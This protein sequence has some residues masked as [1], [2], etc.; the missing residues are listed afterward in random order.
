MPLM[1]SW[2]ATIFTAM[3][4][5]QAPDG[6]DTLQLYAPV[7]V[8]PHGG[9]TS[10]R[11]SAA[12]ELVASAGKSLFGLDRLELGRFVESPDD[13]SQR[14]GTTNGCLYHVDHL[15]T[16]IGPL[17]PALGAG[18]HRTPLAGLYLSGAGT[19]PSGGVSGLPG[20]HA[21]TALLRDHVGRPRR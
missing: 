4:P 6:Q 8:H 7:P 16:R 1:S 19:H 3:D 12:D 11:E 2:W 13:L 10:A 15:P 21:A 20:K 9:W 18:G 17:R 5:T 14:T